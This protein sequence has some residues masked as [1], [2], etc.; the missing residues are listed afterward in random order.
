[1]PAPRASTRAGRARLRVTVS[2]DQLE[3]YLHCQDCETAPS[4]VEIVE[5][6]TAQRIAI[7]PEVDQ[8]IDA[9]VAEME[10]GLIPAE[11][12][13]IAR[14]KA[15]VPGR[16][17]RFEPGSALTS[18]G[19]PPPSGEEGAVNFYEQTRIPLVEKGTVLGRLV[20]ARPGE[21]GQ[22]VFGTT[23]RA[24]CEG[25]RFDL[26]ENVRLAEDGE[27]VEATEAG[28]V[29]LSKHGI[30]V[31]P[32]V[33]I[34]G[35]VSF[36]TG[37][38]RC[39]PAVIVTGDVLDRFVVASKRSVT[40]QGAVEAARIESGEAVVVM[41]GIIGRGYGRVTSRGTVSAAY[42][43]DATLIADGDI[44]LLR[45]A[46]HSQIRTKT[47]LTIERG[48]LIG[49]YAHARQEITV[50]ELGSEA[51]VLTVVSVGLP[52]GIAA[53]KFQVAEQVREKREA[54]AA[55]R[56][57]V[58][59][60]LTGGKGMSGRQREQATS[61]LARAA[62]LETEAADLQRQ[63]EQRCAAHKPAGTPVVRVLRTVYPRVCVIVN[64]R[65]ATLT[66]ALRGPLRFEVRKVRDSEELV[67]VSEPGGSVHVI[68]SKPISVAMVRE[69]NLA[70]E[71][72]PPGESPAKS[73]EEAG[74]RP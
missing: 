22:S 63:F 42:C 58:N 73:S 9:L 41:Q 17:G 48:R 25:Q 47:S 30:S 52:P 53:E 12:R 35:N 38:I 67:A 56:E 66:Q 40:V 23:L 54:A 2:R 18:G 43:V 59:P 31:S 13:V 49:G 21:D 71:P 16:Y 29:R 45:E 36:E 6:L 32:C 5:A 37:N 60:L 39:E 70:L 72:A 4:R 46:R 62:F 11:P 50:R 10:E 26:G 57:Q 1:M 19:K 20:D 33:E 44:T 68:P 14:G 34:R 28:M 8:A 61:L 3:A 24:P 7:T 74:G 27:T 64:G 15:P 69:M 55:I 65:M 51:E